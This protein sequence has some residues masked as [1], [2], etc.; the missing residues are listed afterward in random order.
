M[1][2]SLSGPA[3]LSFDPLRGV[4]VGLSISMD[5][6][7]HT[8]NGSEFFE[9]D[10]GAAGL[11]T[12]R[13]MVLPPSVVEVLG[14]VATVDAAGRTF[15]F[16]C[17]T[18]ANATATAA[19]DKAAV[20]ARLRA[21]TSRATYVVGTATRRGRHGV[22]PVRMQVGASAPDHLRGGA[23]GAAPMLTGL[24]ALDATSG[25]F[26]FARGMCTDMSAEPA[27]LERTILGGRLS[28]QRRL[29]TA[30]RSNPRSRIIVL[31]RSQ[32][33]LRML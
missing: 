4:V 13:T 2:T 29:S 3:A 15:Y 30:T 19:D 9:I 31:V 12:L 24:C 32:I 1:F 23:R 14:G 21:P 8:M 5:A 18:S 6:A 26:K 25:A 27:V 11:T 22:R 16:E 33:R 20:A 17:I 10:T 7:S 28:W